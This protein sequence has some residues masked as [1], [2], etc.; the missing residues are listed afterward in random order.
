[1]YRS[2]Y[3]AILDTKTKKPIKGDLTSES[4]VFFH[5]K[6]ICLT[7]KRDSPQREELLIEMSKQLPPEW[8]RAVALKCSRNQPPAPVLSHVNQLLPG[9]IINFSKTLNEIN[10]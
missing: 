2:C 1:M 7:R 4:D 5:N 8:F 3:L 9:G 10:S 6:E